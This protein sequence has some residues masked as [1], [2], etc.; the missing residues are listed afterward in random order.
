MKKIGVVLTA[1]AL[2][3]VTVMADQQ[4]TTVTFKVPSSI[5]HSIA[6][7]AACANNDFAFVESDGTK[8]GTQTMINVTQIDE[9]ACQTDAVPAMNISNTGNSA[10]NVTM[11]YTA[12]VPAGT[13]TKASQTFAGYEA[14]ACTDDQPPDG[15]V[16]L[17]I[18]DTSKTIILNLAADAAQEIW[19]WCD[20][21]NFNGG[22]AGTDTRTLR[23]TATG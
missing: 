20:M 13:T 15:N 3:C 7:A 17:T 2:L 10:I 19:L 16:C 5:S 4:D 21:S 18:T 12:A 22:A 11:N 9:T 14:G 23:T 8:D 1:M 6:Y